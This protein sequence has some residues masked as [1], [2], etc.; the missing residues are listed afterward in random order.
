MP[1]EEKTSNMKLLKVNMTSI[2][3][4]PCDGGYLQIDTGYEKDYDLYRKKLSKTGIP[5]EKIRYIF[6]THHHDDHAGFLNQL[7][8]DTNA[9]VIMHERSVDLLASGQN[10]K[11]RGGGY[12][13][14]YVKLLAGLKMRL[15]PHWTLSFPPYQIRPMDI[16]VNE[17]DEQLLRR[18][19]ISGKILYTPGHCIDH[20]SLILDSGEAFCGDAAANMLRWAGTKY[21]T[22]FMTDMKKAYSSWDRIVEAGATHILPSHGRAFSATKLQQYRG[23]IKNQDLASF[24]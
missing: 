1:S 11:S 24:F 8:R 23:Q 16:T 5:I 9:V 6:L 21:C 7:T 2:Y 15:D 4:L 22:V 20:I 13:N 12:V 3:L 17:R 18:F 19:G 10:D 14:N